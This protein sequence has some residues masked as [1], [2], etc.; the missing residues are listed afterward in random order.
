MRSNIFLILLLSACFFAK[1]QDKQYPVLEKDSITSK[2]Y[3]L[4]FL[5]ED[6]TFLKNGAD[7]K[8]RMIQAFFKV[9]PAEAKDFNKKTARKVTFIIDPGYQG[10]A[11]TGGT[12]VHYNPGW[13]LRKPTD[14]DVVT[15]EVMHIVQ[16]YGYSAGPVW[17]TEGIADYVRYK[18]GVDNVGSNWRLPEYNAK[19]NYTQSYRITARFFVWLEKLKPGTI[20]EIDSRLRAHTYNDGAWKDLTGKTIDELWGDYIANPALTLVYN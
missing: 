13:M 14:V 7:V 17:L 15:H 6:S 19:Q 9:Y 5:D 16:E 3:T 4:I 11:A 1:A 20:K 12:E 8:A 10:V 2:S 18:Y